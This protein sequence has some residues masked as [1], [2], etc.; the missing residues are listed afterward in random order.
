MPKRSSNH[1]PIRVLAQRAADLDAS[2]IDRLY[3]LEPIFEP[4]QTERGS[5]LGA[6]VEIQC[7]WC[8]EVSG[9]TV[10]LTTAD[11]VWIEDC[12]VCCRAMQVE[13]ELDEAGEIASVST[14]RD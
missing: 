9:T 14:R 8:G 1:S 7:P 5:A 13:I 10:D 2:E 6:F 3:G 12:Q 4:G 11:R